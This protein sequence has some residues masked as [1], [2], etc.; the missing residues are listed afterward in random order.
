MGVA[1]RIKK[2]AEELPR[3]WRDPALPFI[4]VRYVAD[5]R[6]V[7]YEKHS[8]A[9]FSIGAILA[10]ESSYLHGD[11]IHRVTAGSLVLVNPQQAHA[12]NPIRAQAWSYYMFYVDAGWLAALQGAVNFQPFS[13]HLSRDQHLFD[14]LLKLYSKLHTDSP[15][16]V[17]TQAAEQYFSDLYQR[18]RG[19]ASAFPM[20]VAAPELARKLQRAADYIDTHFQSDLNIADICAYAGLSASYLFRSF[21][22]HY[23]MSP[24]AYLINRRVQFAQTRLQQGQPIA[25]VALEAGFADQ[26]HLQRMFKRLLAATPGQYAG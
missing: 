13:V 16:E 11:V 2:S 4:E 7:C 5:G 6:R 14:G 18:L 12:C 3:F 20:T 17:K 15:A 9:R 26:A 25:D 8:H 22:R 21:S 10:G 19:H 23:G 24:H 1:R